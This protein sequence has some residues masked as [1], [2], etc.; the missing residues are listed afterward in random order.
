MQS[1]SF[2]VVLAIVAP[3]AAHAQQGAVSSQCA[4]Q[5]SVSQDA[6]QKAVDLYNFMAPQLGV[7][8]TGGNAILGSASTLGGL[9]H[10]TVG[11]RANIVN[12]Q[13]P[14]SST[15]NISITGA[16]SSNFSPKSQILGLP[17]ADAAI[18]LFQGINVGLTA[19]GGVD[20][21]LSAFY[22]PD[23]DKDP[24]AVRTTGGR[25]RLGYG[26][27][28]GILQES[29]LVPGI[30]VSFLK[31]DLPTAD[32]RAR[33]GASDSVSV[34]GLKE[35]T[36]AWRLAASKSVVLAS[37]TAGVGRDTYDSQAGASAFIA[38]RNLGG[39]ITASFNGSVASAVKRPGLAAMPPA[40]SSFTIDARRAAVAGVSTCVPGVVSVRTCI[41][42][43]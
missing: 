15:I 13:L 12:G 1:R 10:F 35:K 8:I 33:I 11:V 19:V 17:T 32:L 21:L 40:N 9:G 4:A 27:R 30:S 42:I 7:S 18:G 5:L 29:A 23:I 16:Q 34:T 24:V 28:V 25:L 41:S 36:T 37:F 26:L 6:C 38:P 39:G 20:A 14:Q 43:P 3:L 22:V 31:R 2:F